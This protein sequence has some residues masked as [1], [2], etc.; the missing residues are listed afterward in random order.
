MHRQRGPRM[1]YLA[2]EDSR[3]I[4]KIGINVAALVVVALVLVVVSGLLT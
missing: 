4:K 3:T 1:Q 2:S